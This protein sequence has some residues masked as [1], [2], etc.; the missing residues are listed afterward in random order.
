MCCYKLKH[1]LEITLQELSLSRK[2]TQLLQ[3]DVNAQPDFGTVSTKA[4]SN[5][6]LNFEKIN[7]KLRRKKLI[8]NKW[9][10]N[11]LLKLQQSQPITVVVNK[12][13]ISD[14]LQEES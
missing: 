2:I 13:T 14:S 4:N 10:N 8:S 1:E 7:T 12:Y 6:V 9:E 11:T 3:E 5:H